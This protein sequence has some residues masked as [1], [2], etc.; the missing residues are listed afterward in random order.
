MMHS[1]FAAR[2][3]RKMEDNV[4][5]FPRIA[6]VAVLVSALVLA[7]GNL[8]FG[9]TPAANNTQTANNSQITFAP[10][11]SLALPA[12]SAAS[13]NRLSLPALKPPQYSTSKKL[14]IGIGLAMTGVGAAMLIAKE[15]PHQTT[16]VPYDACPTPG[17]VKITG[18]TMV[19]IGV[20]LTILKLRR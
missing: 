6:F 20:P 3:N 16:C 13:A 4:K 2:S 7:P 14:G 9:Q 8:A 12:A 18:A 5:H 19:G 15:N 1:L 17:I 11:T 10:L